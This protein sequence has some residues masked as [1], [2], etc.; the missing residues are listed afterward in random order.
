MNDLAHDQRNLIAYDYGTS[1]TG[2]ALTVRK[3]PCDML[4]ILPTADPSW[5]ICPATGC[6]TTRLHC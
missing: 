1:V 2:G 4:P 6:R 5:K 3:E